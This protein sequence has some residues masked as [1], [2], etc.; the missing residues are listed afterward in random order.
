MWSYGSRRRGG[1]RAGGPRREELRSLESAAAAAESVIDAADSAAFTAD[2]AAAANV[3]ARGDIGEELGPRA[4]GRGA[5]RI[6]N[7]T[8]DVFL[9]FGRSG[10]AGGIVNGD[11]CIRCWIQFL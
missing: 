7:G 2:S 6:L 10:M 3:G 1:A 5:R 4:E 9:P 11:V 8:G